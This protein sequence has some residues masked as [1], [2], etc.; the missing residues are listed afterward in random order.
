M[1]LNFTIYYTIEGGIPVT[2]S[3]SHKLVLG[4]V[5]KKKCGWGSKLIRMNV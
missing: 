1:R 5:K 4:W 3:T 2:Y